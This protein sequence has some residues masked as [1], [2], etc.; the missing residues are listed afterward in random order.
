[1]AAPMRRQSDMPQRSG[2]SCKR[3]SQELSARLKFKVRMDEGNPGL[4]ANSG[5]KLVRTGGQALRARTGDK[6]IAGETLV[7]LVSD[8]QR[9]KGE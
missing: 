1:M 8:A 9:T 2:R 3:T 7:D 5:A 6:I 4:T